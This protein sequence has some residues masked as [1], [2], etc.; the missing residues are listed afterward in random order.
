MMAYS[1]DTKTKI[2]TLDGQE[3]Y[4]RAVYDGNT[5]KTEMFALTEDECK[6]SK[7]IRDTVPAQQL[8]FL[9]MKRNQKLAESDWTQTVDSSLSD[10]KKAE[11]VKYRTAL[12][13]ITKTYKSTE[14]DGF[15]WPTKPE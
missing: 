5:G 4:P 13:D 12:K 15:K 9:R 1:V 10:S 8:E 2:A 14:D 3:Y 7:E 6:E 11:W